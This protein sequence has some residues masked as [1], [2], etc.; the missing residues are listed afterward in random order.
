MVRHS[1][2]GRPHSY[3]KS[4]GF[5]C[6]TWRLDNDPCLELML[7]HS[8]WDWPLAALVRRRLPDCRCHPLCRL[9]TVLMGLA[10]FMSV[11]MLR[12]RSVGSDGSSMRWRA[13]MRGICCSWRQ[14]PGCAVGMFPAAFFAG[15]TLPL[16]TLAL[17]RIGGG[18]RQIGRVYASNTLGAIVGV[19]VMVH[20][21]V[22][23]MGVRLA[24][25]LSALV[26]A[27]LGLYLLRCVSPGRRTI[28]Y[29]L[30]GVATLA[31]MSFGAL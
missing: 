31:F 28:G 25:I 10:A 2:P 16:F 12:S 18:E 1:L 7:R 27:G 30:A 19:L 11:V 17:L 4:A 15:M 20:V 22:P 14:W 5:A 6:S 13:M 26:D 8:S 29:A 23:M 24:I 21:L 9:R 3:M